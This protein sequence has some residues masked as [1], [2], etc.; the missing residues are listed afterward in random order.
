FAFALY[1]VPGLWGAPLK[2]ISAF[3]PP[4]STQDFDLFKVQLRNNSGA[5]TESVKTVAVSESKKYS[6]I[7]HCPHDINC[8]FDYEQGL[9]VARQQ[10]KP[11]MLDFT[12]WSC[13]N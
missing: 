13:V 12:G 5:A 2:A 10:N 8:Y 1:M 3:A 6:D 4:Q 11:V 9:Q 7:F